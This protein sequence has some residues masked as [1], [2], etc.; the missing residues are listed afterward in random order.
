MPRVSKVKKTPKTVK[1]VLR[2]T[3]IGKLMTSRDTEECTI[4]TL[5]KKAWDCGLH[6]YPRLIRLLLKHDK[7]TF[8]D[9]VKELRKPSE[10][11]I[12]RVKLN[13]SD[14][15][16]EE[17]E[18]TCSRCKSKKVSKMELQTRSSDES[19]TTFYR[20]VN[21]QKRWKC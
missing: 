7:W 10:K 21:C 4:R 2:D 11:E 19:A 15:Y 16:V 9:A 1:N 6:A 18:V 5:E 20:C 17:G 13:D 8:K 14:K 12:E 3:A